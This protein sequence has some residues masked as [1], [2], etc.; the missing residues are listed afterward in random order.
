LTNKII[1]ANIIGDK[2][3]IHIVNNQPLTNPIT[4]PAVNIPNVIKMTPNFDV[5]TISNAWVY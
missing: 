3:R 5:K 2:P 4:I 1:A